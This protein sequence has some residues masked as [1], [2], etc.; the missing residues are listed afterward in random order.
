[1]LVVR[2][3]RPFF[4]SRPSQL[5]AIATA[6]VVLAAFLI[7]HFPVAPLL[8]FTPMPGKF[9]AI[10]ATIVLVY[11]VAAEITKRTFYRAAI[12]AGKSP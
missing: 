4:N 11:V 7:P 1:V 6:A 3:R 2:S 8:G 12:K 9:Y 5:L 10:V